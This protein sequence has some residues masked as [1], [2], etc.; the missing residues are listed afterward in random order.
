MGIKK[1]V[2]GFIVIALLLTGCGGGSSFSADNLAIRKINDKKQV[3]RYGM[4]RTDAEK[5][6]GVGEKQGD[7]VGARNSY[8]Y[9]SGVVIAYRDDKVVVIL[10]NEGSSDVYETSKGARVGMLKGE[11][12]EM[13][14]ENYLKETNERNLDYIYDSVN[15]K[16]IVDSGSMKDLKADNKTYMIS[17]TFNSDGYAETVMLLDREFGVYLR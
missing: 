2:A 13:Y 10:L 3:V 17:S 16:F 4:T 7:G 9:E 6:L 15:K 8:N 14:G 5:V 1:I 11:I 12:E